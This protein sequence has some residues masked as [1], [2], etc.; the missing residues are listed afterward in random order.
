MGCHTVVYYNN[1]CSAANPGAAAS[2]ALTNARGRYAHCSARRRRS[3][4]WNREI[5]RYCK[6]VVVEFT[7]GIASAPRGDAG[8]TP[9]FTRSR[10]LIPYSRGRA[11]FR[12]HARVQPARFIQCLCRWANGAVPGSPRARLRAL[13]RPYPRTPLRS[14]ARGVLSRRYGAESGIPPSR[15]LPSN[16]VSSSGCAGALDGTGSLFSHVL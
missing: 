4:G 15:P 3:G 10:Y 6:L 2:I 11:A 8:L 7:S 9:V 13:R 14:P 16:E 5:S 12:A 1:R